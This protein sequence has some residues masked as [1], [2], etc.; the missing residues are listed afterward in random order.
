[1]WASYQPRGAEWPAT[2]IPS[3]SRPDFRGSILRNNAG[4]E[5]PDMQCLPC[6]TSPDGLA[7]LATYLK[8]PHTGPN[9]AL[10]A[11]NPGLGPKPATGL[12][13]ESWRFAH[14]TLPISVLQLRKTSRCPPTARKKRVGYPRG[15]SNS[16]AEISRYNLAPGKK[17]SGGRSRDAGAPFFSPRREERLTWAEL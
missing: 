15:P 12:V 2:V 14:T 4:A 1:M 3:P 8:P 13:R 16:Q 5:T 6:P 17:A 7:L 9:R 10:A 11:R